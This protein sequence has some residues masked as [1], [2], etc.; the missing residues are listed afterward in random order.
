MRWKE[1]ARANGLG[2]IR[3]ETVRGGA[4]VPPLRRGIPT[5]TA[6]P[7]WPA[8]RPGHAHD[9]PTRMPNLAQSGVRNGMSKAQKGMLRCAV[10]CCVALRMRCA[11]NKYNV[12]AAEKGASRHSLSPWQRA[13]IR[14]CSRHGQ[15]LQATFVSILA[16]QD[17]LATDFADGQPAGRRRLHC[18]QQASWP[19]RL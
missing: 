14:S 19:A 11:A 5:G 6:A 13:H 2:R 3:E 16:R 7:A 12:P 17:R 18:G 4:V 9:D 1:T 10:L 8:S 15:L